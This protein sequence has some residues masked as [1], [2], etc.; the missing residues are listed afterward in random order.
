M[1]D[2]IHTFREELSEKE[3]R[4]ATSQKPRTASSDVFRKLILS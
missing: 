3:I 4:L 2:F 1:F